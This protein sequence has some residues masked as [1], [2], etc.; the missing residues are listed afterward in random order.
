M[1]VA[2][3]NPQSTSTLNLN[4]DNLVNFW[5]ETS[6]PAPTA[7]NPEMEVKFFYTPIGGELMEKV[8]PSFPSIE[9]LDFTIRLALDLKLE[10][11]AVDESFRDIYLDLL[12]RAK[13]KN[14]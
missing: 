8:L 4:I 14:V 7:G 6:I 1:I 2:I 12:E 11:L 13:E 3:Y 10:T 5:V 9:Y